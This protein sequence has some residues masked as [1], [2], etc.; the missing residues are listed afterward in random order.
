MQQR[1]RRKAIAKGAIRCRPT[2]GYDKEHGRL[3][4]SSSSATRRR[5]LE[6]EFAGLSVGRSEARAEMT[7]ITM[8]HRIR[9]VVI[10]PCTWSTMV[11]GGDRSPNRQGCPTAEGIYNAQE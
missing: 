7:A 6:A 4:R 8:T 3:C 1:P 11:S 5:R 2:P 9:A 10:R